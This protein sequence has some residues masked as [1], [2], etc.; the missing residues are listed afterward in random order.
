MIETILV[1]LSLTAVD[2]DTVKCDGKNM[3][4]LGQGVP[5]QVGIDT[6][7]ITHAKCKK[8]LKLAQ[9]AKNRLRELLR[10]D[11]LTVVYSGFNDKTPQRRPLVD[12]YNADGIEVGHQMLREGFAREWRP[13]HKN[14]WC[15]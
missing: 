13:R 3:R 12:I 1:C 4:L 10:Q 2:G 7:E 5:Y 14:N 9:L 11:G 8:E 15:D 6:P